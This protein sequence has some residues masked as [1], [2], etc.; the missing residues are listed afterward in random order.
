MWIYKILCVSHVAH[1]LRLLGGQVSSLQLLTLCTGASR[2]NVACSCLTQSS[3]GQM[4]NLD[5]PCVIWSWFRRGPLRRPRWS[6]S[7]LLLNCTAWDFAARRGSCILL[8]PLSDCWTICCS[9]SLVCFARSVCTVGHMHRHRTSWYLY[10]IIANKLLCS[11]WLLFDVCLH[12]RAVIWK[13]GVVVFTI[14]QPFISE[15]YPSENLHRGS[16]ALEPAH[17]A[18]ADC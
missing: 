3:G 6:G 5:V 8:A 14:K 9:I 11:F 18:R 17:G 4:L 10:C 7:R 15:L 2:G 12:M 16:G 1:Y 13:R